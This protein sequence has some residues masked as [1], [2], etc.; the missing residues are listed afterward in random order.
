MLF[1]SLFIL[2]LSYLLKTASLITITL[3]SGNFTFTGIKE[4]LG[5]YKV[6]ILLSRKRG[7]SSDAHVYPKVEHVY[8]QSLTGGSPYNLFQTCMASN[9]NPEKADATITKAWM[10]SPPFQSLI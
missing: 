3:V 7:I 8:W 5:V 1:R 4:K 6:Q 9:L 2:E 10:F